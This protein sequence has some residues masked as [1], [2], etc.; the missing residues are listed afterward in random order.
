MKIRPVTS[1]DASAIA[2]VHIRSWREAF[3]LSE[4]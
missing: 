1:E 4:S 2:Q 3:S